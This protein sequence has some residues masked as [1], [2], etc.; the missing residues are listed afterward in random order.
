MRKHGFQV[1]MTLIAMVA[2]SPALV[3]AEVAV[4]LGDKSDDFD[5]KS[6]AEEF[7]E[8]DSCGGGWFRD[9]AWEGGFDVM[10][11]TVYANHGVGGTGSDFFEDFD[12]TFDVRPWVGVRR[13]DG[14]GVHFRYFDF[15]GQSTVADEFVDIK[16][17][18]V[19]AS[20]VLE[21]CD[22]QFT[23]IAG[24]R[25]AEIG[26]SDENANDGFEFRGIGML[27]GGEVRRLLQNNL[28]VV[29]KA[30]YSALFGEVQEVADPSDAMTGVAVHG[31]QTALMVEW[32]RCTQL[33]L[34]TI[35]AGWE[36][37]LYASLSGNVDSDIDPED[38][39]IT[40]AGPVL[41]VSVQR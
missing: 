7:C 35:G 16:L 38:V 39:D 34:V 4:A 1:L 24:T 32:S 11:F 13:A 2:L 30:R 26:W 41:S 40:L 37:Q 3:R 36:Q 21:V 8:D 14:L 29:G 27:L 10:F 28:S 15:D 22:W 17:F 18:D 19:E 20:G 25:Y 5:G 31:L 33:G 9:A 12:T 23:A 6:V